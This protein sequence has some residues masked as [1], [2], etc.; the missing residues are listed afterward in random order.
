[1]NFTE[2]GSW[3]KHKL[4]SLRGREGARWVG[5]AHSLRF[6]SRLY[7]PWTCGE[8]K[9][10][11]HSLLV[12]LRTPLIWSWSYCFYN[13]FCRDSFAFSGSGQISKEESQVSGEEVGP[14]S[15]RPD[16]DGCVR[17]QR[18]RRHL[19]GSCEE[20]SEG[21]RI[22]RGEEQRQDP[23]HHQTPGGQQSFGPDQGLRGL[24]LLQAE[25][26][27]SCTSKEESGDQE[28]AKEV[29]RDQC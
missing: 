4:S 23:H 11:Y 17:F 16:T 27:G 22:R 24:R 18:A 20:G 29:W 1:M 13:V 12:S 10:R 2:S 15:V 7:Q 8:G 9:Q 5:L 21:W 28:Q 14:Y 26:K 3:R 25:Q 6:S 19:P